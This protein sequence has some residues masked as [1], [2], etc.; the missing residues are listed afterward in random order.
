MRSNKCFQAVVLTISTGFLSGCHGIQSALDPAGEQAERIRDLWLIFFWVTLGVYL[1]VL[2]FLLFSVYR[3]RGIQQQV[4]AAEPVAAPAPRQE[5]RLGTV[6]GSAVGVTIVVLFVLF[7][8][9]LFAGRALHNLTDLDPL[10]VKVT[11]HQW[12]WEVK[13]LDP[14]PSNIVTTAN[15]IHVPVGKAVLF[16]LDS[17]DVIHS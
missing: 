10:K 6:I 1:L 11:G 8:S 7:V 17:V 15:E 13:Y 16:Q 2:L 4:A 9:D 12:W 3:A 14:I 5:R